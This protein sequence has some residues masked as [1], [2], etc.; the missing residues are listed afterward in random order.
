M[1]SV[2]RP[3]PVKDKVQLHI[4]ITIYSGKARKDRAHSSVG[5]LLHEEYQQS[6]EDI[7]YVTLPSAKQE[8]KDP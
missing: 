1:I 4:P 6:I 3:K 7:E 8:A 5:I 2:A